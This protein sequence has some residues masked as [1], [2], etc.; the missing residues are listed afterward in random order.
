M[1]Y[2][3]AV[4]VKTGKRL[5]HTKCSER[6]IIFRKQIYLTKTID[7]NDHLGDEQNACRWW[8]QL[9]LYMILITLIRKGILKF[10]WKHRQYLETILIKNN[11]SLKHILRSPKTLLIFSIIYLPTIHLTAI[12]TF[13]RTF[14]HAP[15]TCY[16]QYT[17]TTNTAF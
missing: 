12:I 6:G 17:L 11:Y 13:N 10:S 4:T 15:E 14:H 3:L 8:L 2:F 5:W 1:A 9:N 16:L 7:Q